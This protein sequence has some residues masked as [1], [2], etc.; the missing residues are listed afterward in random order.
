M[1]FGTLCEVQPDRLALSGSLNVPKSEFFSESE[2]FCGETAAAID[3]PKRLKRNLPSQQ[4]PSP[5]PLPTL[6][7]FLAF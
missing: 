3:L 6:P 1:N 5:P 7:L 4:P 2:K